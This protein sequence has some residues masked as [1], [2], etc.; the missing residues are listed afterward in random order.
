MRKDLPVYL[1]ET[2]R[3]GWSAGVLLAQ[4]DPF[5]RTSYTAAAALQGASA[6]TGTRTVSGSST[7]SAWSI[8]KP[9]AGT[10]LVPNGAVTA[11]QVSSTVLK[12]SFYHPASYTE[13][14]GEITVTGHA[15]RTTTITKL[16]ASSSPGFSAYTDGGIQ[17]QVCTFDEDNLP[18]GEQTT[19]VW[20]NTGADSAV[21]VST[22]REILTIVEEGGIAVSKHATTTTCSLSGSVI[23]R[24]V[25]HRDWPLLASATGVSFSSVSTDHEEVYRLFSWGEELVQEIFY[26]DGKGAG[27]YPA[28]VWEYAWWDDSEPSLTGS[29]K[30]TIEKH[31]TMTGTLGTAGIVDT[32]SWITGTWEGTWAEPAPSSENTVQFS[33]KPFNDGYIIPSASDSLSTFH[34]RLSSPWA[35]V[36]V[37]TTLSPD[38]D[39]VA[40]RKLIG[41]SV[42]ESSADSAPSA[43]LDEVT[44]DADGTTSFLTSTQFVVGG[45]FYLEPSVS[46]ALRAGEVTIDDENLI[47]KSSWHRQLLYPDSSAPANVLLATP[48]SSYGGEPPWKVEWHTD[49]QFPESAPSGTGAATDRLIKQCELRD[50]TSGNLLVKKRFISTTDANSSDVFAD[51]TYTVNKLLETEVWTYDDS[52]RPLFRR[53][54]GEIVESWTYSSTASSRSTVHTD[55]QGLKTT[56]ERDLHDRPVSFISHGDT[57]AG[58]KHIVTTWSYGGRGDGKSGV[59]IIKT[60]NGG[61]GWVSTSKKEYD[62]I[63]RLVVSQD[64]GGP[65][66]LTGEKLY[67]TLYTYSMDS[68]GGRI[69]NTILNSSPQVTQLTEKF[70][71]DGELKSRSGQAVVAETFS[72]SGSAYQQ[73]R[74]NYY[75]SSLSD[76]VKTDGLGRP[77]VLY[78]PLYGSGSTTN[79]FTENRYYDSLGRL[80]AKRIPST[81]GT[82]HE[83]QKWERIAAGTIAHYTALSSDN[84]VYDSTDANRTRVLSSY[85]EASPYGGSTAI[86]WESGEMAVATGPGTSGSAG[87]W[88]TASVTWRDALQ[89]ASMNINGV[90][91][92]LPKFETNEG[93]MRS[94]MAENRSRD[95]RMV[96]RRLWRN[97]STVRQLL[98]IRNGLPTTFYAP[99]I[100]TLTLDHTPLGEPL[101]EPSFTSAYWPKVDIDPATGRITKQ[102][103]P[104]RTTTGTDVETASYAYYSA[105]HRNAGLL[106]SATDSGTGGVT[107]FDY[108]NRAQLTHQWGSGDYPQR[109]GYDS[110]GR[111]TQL[112][113]WRTTASSSVNWSATTWPSNADTTGGPFKSTTAWS[114]AGLTDLLT[115]KTYPDAGTGNRVVTYNYNVAGKLSSRGSQRGVSTSFTYDGYARPW[116]VNYSDTTPD[117][118][119]SYHPDSGRRVSVNEGTLSGSIFTATRSTAYNHRFDGSITGETI[120]GGGATVNLNRG[121]DSYGRLSALNQSWSQSPA[122]T[123]AS[124]A[125]SYIYDGAHRLNTVYAANGSDMM[126]A[127]LGRSSTTENVSVQSNYYAGNSVSSTTSRDIYGRATLRSFLG[128][129]T[130]NSRMAW[131]RD[132]LVARGRSGTSDRW[133]YRYNARGEIAEAWKQFGSE[134]TTPTT[135]SFPAASTG[136]PSN[137]VQAGTG[138]VYAYDD[139]GNRTSKGDI[140]RASVST[141]GGNPLVP[142]DSRVTNYLSSASATNILNQYKVI[143]NPQYFSVR[144]TRAAGAII[145]VNGD[146]TATP[147]PTADS[148]YQQ[149][150]TGTY[151]R[152]EVLNTAVGASSPDLYEPVQVTSGGSVITVDDPVQYVPKASES[153]VYD[154]DGNLTSDG[155]WNYTWD[156]ADRLIRMESVAWQQTASGGVPPGT[157]PAKV[158]EFGYDAF[159]RRIRKKVYEKPYGSSAWGLVTWEA[160]A[161]DGWN[162]TGRYKLTAASAPAVFAGTAGGIVESLHSTSVWGPDTGSLL[163]AGADWQSAGGVDGLLMVLYAKPSSAAIPTYEY[164]LTYYMGLDPEDPG[165]Y[166]EYYENYIVLWYNNHDVHVPVT[167]H[168]GNVT[169]VVRLKSTPG[170]METAVHEFVYDYDAFGKEIRSS[171]LV[172]GGNPDSFPYHYSTKFTD[173]ETGLNYFGYRFY[174]PE[175][176]R[177]IN[178]DPIEE[179]GGINLYGMI[180][181]DAANG[182]DVLGLSPDM[183]TKAAMLA[184]I[185][186]TAAKVAPSAKK[187]AE[188]KKFQAKMAAEKKVLDAAK[189]KKEADRLK[190]IE[191]FQ[192]KQKE[193]KEAAQKAKEN[194]PAAKGPVKPGQPGP[195]DDLKKQKKKHGETEPM[196]MDHRPSLAA[197]VKAAEK[198]KGGSLTKA[199][200]AKVKAESPAVATPRLD[201][202]QKSRTYGGRNT[203]AK[204]TADAADLKAA[205]IND[206]AAYK[207]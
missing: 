106:F 140:G 178:R 8:S 176:G 145:A 170:S 103:L 161:Y 164:W 86:W 202:Q 174:D 163:D 100:G 197:Q 182:F 132:R 137:E 67:E 186:S 33:I 109:Y 12:F 198:A 21:S 68:S 24:K 115:T 139:I 61:G 69:E 201:H 17:S 129:G 52:D 110:L 206:D 51:T 53:L 19:T 107:Y 175:R 54:N 113:T 171:S 153:L 189:A 166:D 77:T 81:T 124:P 105:T 205:K 135:P 184:F 160:Y 73:W 36:V 30:L 167:D 62:G 50:R 44:A 111:R 119:F 99:E 136:S 125:I 74:F 123:L 29:P 11:E 143:S 39:W 185:A 126:T 108:N 131:N 26:P 142:T 172:P 31:G 38:G 18:T 102:Y 122:G 162:L 93:G 60:I 191:E 157:V 112:D 133:E 138:T 6:F 1:G 180:G 82:L 71:C 98:T 158:L 25:Q 80:R 63:G 65:G 43:I 95:T 5:S 56:D 87:A 159:S 150:G 134:V 79:Y 94:L 183:P 177:W 149:G 59:S 83:V 75:S 58:E 168:M 88:D 32:A 13:D 127:S 9:L 84:D 48:D 76:Y 66:D 55:E 169:G 114:Y 128:P 22:P 207:K 148:G 196:D 37:E 194:C 141:G 104:R 14:D 91:N 154:L 70:Y 49:R 57:L 46:H 101:E 117:V 203:D 165:I 34:D 10:G 156:A 116:R 190:A 23:T 2:D 144:G 27:S 85:V 147:T 152:N 155:R 192:K 3:K 188:V 20:T 72:Y 200:L 64:W 187:M 181:N 35:Y 78:Y 120:T 179:A 195:Y 16:A 45:D 97:S 15:H 7:L 173:S 92:Q 42:V 199:E 151:Y 47:S 4:G 40:S 89:E 118:E 41:A 204:S 96:T 130:S 121:F 193:L 146:I 28:I 90:T